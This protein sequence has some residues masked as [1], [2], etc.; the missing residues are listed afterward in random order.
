MPMSL[1][2]RSLFVFVI[3]FFAVSLAN[4]FIVYE[5]METPIPRYGTVDSAAIL[6]A[7]AIAV[8]YWL[9]WSSGRN[10]SRP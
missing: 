4:A 10:A 5:V 2:F 8:F 6:S 7:A 9:K 1:F 3:V